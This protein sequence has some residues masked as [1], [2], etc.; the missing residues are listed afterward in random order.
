MDVIGQLHLLEQVASTV[1]HIGTLAEKLLE[2][3]REN[4]NCDNKV[5]T[6]GVMRTYYMYMEW[7]GNEDILYVH[8]LS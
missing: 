6:G 4:S 8:V 1:H 2:A 7:R 5:M 3:L